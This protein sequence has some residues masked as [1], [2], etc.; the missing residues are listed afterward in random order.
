MLYFRMILLMAISL[1]TSRVILE[2]L[3]VIDYG[4]YNVVSGFLVL[5]SF[6]NSGIS[7]STSRYITY[8]LGKN[9][10]KYLKNVFAICMESHIAIS[11]LILIF[12]ETIGLWI[13]NDI[14]DIPE[15]KLEAAFWVYQ[16]AIIATLIGVWSVPYN[17]CIIA[18]EKMSAFAYISIFEAL[19]KLAIV[20]ILSLFQ[21]DRLIIYAVL[22]VLVQ[23]IVILIYIIYSFRQFEESKPSLF[24]EKHLFK[25]TMLFAGWNLWGGLSSAMFTQGVNILLNVFFGP[26]INTARGLAVTVQS[27][28]Q[29]FSAN[30]Q[31]AINPQIIKTYA[32]NELHQMY[33]LI[34]RSSKFSFIL[35]FC[36]ITPIIIET[37]YILQLWLKDVPEYTSI[38][39]RIMLVIS[40][41]EGMANPFMTAMIATGNV[42]KYHM[43]IGTINLL[44]V[45]ISYL[46]L[47]LGG[48]PTSAFIVQL[49][50]FSLAFIV[51]IKLVSKAITF[52]IANYLQLCVLPCLC[53][54]IC[55]S[56]IIPIKYIIPNHPNITILISFVLNSILSLYVGL[57]TQERLFIYNKISKFVTK[58]L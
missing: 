5:M 30:F 51:R 36:L 24:F 13:V 15:N 47:V 42:K 4:V 31:T 28:V 35:L 41:I 46:I 11:I 8:A 20:F 19:A 22:T 43:I 55:S 45:P 39:V 10:K 3:G 48:N 1:Y 50:I 18:H 29:R 14:L 21:D 58:K 32:N 17:S 54:T 25:E 40:L 56:I 38:F 27:T 53:L 16:C 6:I 26:A 2:E 34:S 49:V 57:S 37:P 44:I 12:A 52:P 33:V 7:S 23:I 9:D